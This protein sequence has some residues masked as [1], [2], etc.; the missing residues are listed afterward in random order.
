MAHDL[1][2]REIESVDATFD[3]EQVMSAFCVG[4]S[5][6]L[7]VVGIKTS[8]KVIGIIRKDYLIE[9]YNQKLVENFKR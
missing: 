2:R 4:G 9:F 3:L 1:V 6:M 7:P 5:R 8:G